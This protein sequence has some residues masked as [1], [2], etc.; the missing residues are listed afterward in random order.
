M[1]N[2]VSLLAG[3]RYPGRGIVLG[4]NEEGTAARIAYFIMGRSENSRNRIFV[5]T[6]ADTLETRAYDES[7]MI[8]PRLII[9]APYRHLS[10]GVHIITNGDQTDTIR[11]YIEAGKSFEEA[12]RTRTFEPDMPNYT[13]RIS[14]LVEIADGNAAFRFSILKSDRGNP[15]VVIRQFFEYSTMPKGEGAFI[16]TY[17]CDG[18]PIPSFEGE[19]ERV[20]VLGDLATWTKEVWDSLDA[21]NRISLFTCELP[22]DG[23]KGQ[24]CLINKYQ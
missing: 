5:K 24:E 10:G 16:H 6:D 13:P 2:M 11:D 19:P 4:M 14:G 8:D 22:V 20:S 17:R 21:D 15:D 18:N 1:E 3:N 7:K 12:L 9:Y 23:S